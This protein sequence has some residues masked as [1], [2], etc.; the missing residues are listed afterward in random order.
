[1]NETFDKNKE[2]TNEN[3]KDKSVLL[4]EKKPNRNNEMKTKKMRQ[5][6]RRKLINTQEGLEMIKG[7]LLKMHNIPIKEPREVS[8]FRNSKRTTIEFPERLEAV[9]YTH[10]DVYKRQIIPFKLS[11]SR[12]KCSKMYVV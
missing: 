5:T 4:S 2:E 7:G 11:R 1:M 6:R 10:L 9:S 12:R 3:K 8:Q